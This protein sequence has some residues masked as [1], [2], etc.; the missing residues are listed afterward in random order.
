MIKNVG[1]RVYEKFSPQ[2]YLYEEM[3]KHQT[4]EYVK[5]KHK[6]FSKLNNKKMKIKDALVA[7]DTFVDPSDPDVDVPNSIHAYQTAERIRKKYPKNIEL[8][9]TGLIHDLGKVLFSFGEPNWSIVGDTYVVGCKFPKSIVYYD[10]M[11]LNPDYYKYDEL[12]IYKEKCGLDN[13][14]ISY[15]HD[16]YLYQV[17]LQNMDKHKLSKKYLDIIR[18]HSFYPWHTSGDYKKFMDESDEIKLK[19]VNDFNECDLY[20]KEDDTNI[21][22]GIKKYYNY[23]LDE[24]FPEELQW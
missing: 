15:G 17:L 1:L 16:E 8:Q 7:L 3:H 6:Q 24:Y 14:Y 9:L 2:Y 22:E 13:L 18:Y 5:Q 19:N 10:T 12:G 11:K 23:Y 21:D 4:L 20:S